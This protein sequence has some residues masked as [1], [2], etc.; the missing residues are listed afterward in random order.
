V[1]DRSEDF[2][3]SVHVQYPVTSLRPWL[4]ASPP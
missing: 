4:L 1:R 2:Y 3:G